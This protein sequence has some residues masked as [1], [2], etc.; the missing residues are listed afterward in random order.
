MTSKMAN[1][2]S[3]SSNEEQNYKSLDKN[4]N[5]IIGISD[6]LILVAILYKITY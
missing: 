4:D 6:D 5:N 2:I 1:D 3:S